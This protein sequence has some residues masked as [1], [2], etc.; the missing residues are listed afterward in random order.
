MKH[1]FVERRQE[2]RVDAVL[3]TLVDV[4]IAYRVNVGDRVAEAFMRET[5]VPAHLA[6]RVLD[7]S[8]TVRTTAPRRHAPQGMPN[9]L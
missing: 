6:Q 7:G 9:R 8:A 2:R 3:A 4:A 1:P 5:G